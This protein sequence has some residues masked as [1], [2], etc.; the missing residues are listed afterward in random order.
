M[1]TG[2]GVLEAVTGAIATHTVDLAHMA[3]AH[4]APDSDPDDPDVAHTLHRLLHWDE[5]TIAQRQRLADH[6]VR[7]AADPATGPARLATEGSTVMTLRCF[8]VIPGIESTPS[9]ARIEEVAPRGAYI[10]QDAAR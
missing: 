5:L 9:L 2:I 1:L 8:S 7:L 10:K 4:M 6:L 3:L